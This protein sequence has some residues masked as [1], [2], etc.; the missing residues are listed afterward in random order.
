[1]DL[2]LYERKYFSDEDCVLLRLTVSQ[3]NIQN[4]NRTAAGEGGHLIIR[5]VPCLD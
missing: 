2:N 1:M 5:T 4:F 3:E